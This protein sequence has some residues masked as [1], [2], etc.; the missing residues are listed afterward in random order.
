VKPHYKLVAV[1]TTPVFRQMVADR[2]LASPGWRHSYR[3]PGNTVAVHH[4]KATLV[5]F[6][7]TDHLFLCRNA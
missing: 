3:K 7:H 2:V 4:D 1:V 6:S 5:L